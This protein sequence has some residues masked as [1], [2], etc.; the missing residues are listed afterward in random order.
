M[1][2]DIDIAGDG[3]A[4][5]GMDAGIAVDGLGTASDGLDTAGDGLDTVGE[6]QGHS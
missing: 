6:G 5:L 4:Q 1:H 3:Q 2:F